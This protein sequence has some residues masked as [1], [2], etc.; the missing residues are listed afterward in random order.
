MDKYQFTINLAGVL[1]AT[2]IVSFAAMTTYV[3]RFLRAHLGNT[4][5]DTIVNIARQ[6]VFAAEEMGLTAAK[7]GTRVSG[8]DKLA[9]AL[10]VFTK[11]AKPGKVK[12][13]TEQAAAAIEAALNVERPLMEA[14]TVEVTES[15]R[16]EAPAD[17]ALAR[18][19]P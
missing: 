10:D 5:M 15:G 1:T 2:I 6:T 19:E 7:S 8:N 4:R 12:V 11:L 13:D 16:H 18:T 3:V 17:D 14:V 9:Y